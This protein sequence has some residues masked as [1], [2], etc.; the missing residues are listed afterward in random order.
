MFGSKKRKAKKEAEK[1]AELNRQAAE[2]AAAEKAA[3]EKAAA[4]K[5][6]AEEAAAEKAAAE[7]AATEKAAKKPA[8]PKAT[9]AAPKAAA[10]PAPKKAAEVKEAPAAQADPTTTK[11]KFEI[12]RT[13]DNRYMF[14]VRA[15]NTQVIASSQI[16]SSM[17]ACR[18]GINSV[19]VNAPIAALEDQTL[20]SINEEK[21]PKFQIYLD[22]GGKYRFNLLAANG[23]N[24]LACTQGYTQKSSCK[25]GIN[26][27]IANA[28]ATIVLPMEEE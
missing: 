6:A 3:A 19:G 18:N 9:K 8:A 14:N 16:Y 7:K 2:K 23:Q 27:V 5:A 24:I 4:E 17:T 28:H 22:K 11:G 10:K 1:Q 25:N 12:K 15:A 26:S 20:S 21:C 13:N